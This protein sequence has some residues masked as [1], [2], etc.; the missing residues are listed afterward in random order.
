MKILEIVI[1]HIE[2]I[3]SFYTHCAK[4]LLIAKKI[5]PN[6]IL[7]KTIPIG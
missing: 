1:D 2:N 7:S 6:L 3:F 5:Q 4:D